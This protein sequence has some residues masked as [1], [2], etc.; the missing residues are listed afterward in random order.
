MPFDIVI[1]KSF[2]SLPGDVETVLLLLEEL[3]THGPRWVEQIALRVDA[4]GPK[5]VASAARNLKAIAGALS[6]KTLRDLAGALER[7]SGLVRRGCQER[8]VA[9]LRKE[10]SRCLGHIPLVVASAR[11]V[12]WAN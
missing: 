1:V 12:T 5:A 7:S 11:D 8:L 4:G 10:M 6:A 9:R 3:Q 2:A